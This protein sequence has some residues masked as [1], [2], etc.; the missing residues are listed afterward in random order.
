MIWMAV[1][2]ELKIGLTSRWSRESSEVMEVISY[3][4]LEAKEGFRVQKGMNFGVRFVPIILMSQRKRS[5]SIR[6]LKMGRSSMRGMMLLKLRCKILD[7]CH[8]K[9]GIN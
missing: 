8:T 3:N 6:C 9:T 7:H 5:I 2:S 4:Q 1:S